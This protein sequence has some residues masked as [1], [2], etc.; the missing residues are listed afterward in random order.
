MVGRNGWGS[1]RVVYDGAIQTVNEFPAFGI[2]LGDLHPHFMALPFTIVALATAAAIA[3]NATP[4][5]WTPVVLAGVLGGALYGLNSW[6]L[7]TYFGLIALALI[8]NGQ[9]MGARAIALRVGR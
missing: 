7:P 1:S 4:V 3:R 6:D 5:G 9:S 8:W 2:I